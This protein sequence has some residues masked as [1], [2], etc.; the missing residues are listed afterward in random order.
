[1]AEGTLFVGNVE[2]LAPTDGEG[3]FPFTLRQLF[4]GPLATLGVL[5]VGETKE[6]CS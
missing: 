4:P 5:E 3:E 1:M 6:A 2:V